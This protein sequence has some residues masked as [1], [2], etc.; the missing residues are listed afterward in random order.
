MFKWLEKN[1]PKIVLTP[2][3]GL[4]GCLYTALY[5]GLYISMSDAI[6]AYSLPISLTTSFKKSI[7]PSPLFDNTLYPI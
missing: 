1:L 5:F 6:C 2:A 4:I 7:S 3:V